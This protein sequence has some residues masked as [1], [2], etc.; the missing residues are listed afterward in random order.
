MLM[1]AG[2]IILIY[3]L[4]KFLRQSFRLSDLIVAPLL[5]CGVIVLLPFATRFLTKPQ[6]RTLTIS[7]E[8]IQT[9]IGAQAGTIPWA[10]VVDIVHDGEYIF[11][12]GHT[13]N[14]FLIPGR[15][16]DTPRERSAFLDAMANYRSVA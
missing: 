7:P 4:P 8:G 14:S 5:S 9:S 2:L 12:I 11:V 1:L 15:A 13:G 16:F 3:L 6:Q 10:N